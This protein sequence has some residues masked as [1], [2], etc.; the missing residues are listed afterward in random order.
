[1]SDGMEYA[2]NQICWWLLYFRFWVR[3]GF[4][5]LYYLIRAQLGQMCFNIVLLHKWNCAPGVSVPWWFDAGYTLNELCFRCINL[6]RNIVHFIKILLFRIWYLI[7]G[8]IYI[9]NKMGW[10]PYLWGSNKQYTGCL[11]STYKDLSLLSPNIYN[12]MKPPPVWLT[13]KQSLLKCLEICHLVDLS[14]RQRIYY[15]YKTYT[16]RALGSYA[17]WQI[18]CLPSYIYVMKPLVWWGPI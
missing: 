13:L 11:P 4:W 7:L 15:P 12:I 6:R 18:N 8:L 9:F 5:F 1:M 3:C 2:M 16:A 14:C 17:R 10:S